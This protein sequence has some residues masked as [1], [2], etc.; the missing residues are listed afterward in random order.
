MVNMNYVIINSKFRTDNN[1]STSNFTYRLG[2]PIEVSD[3]AIKSVSIVNAEYNIKAGSNKLIVNNGIA[4]TTLTVPVGQYDI[5]ALLTVVKNYLDATYGGVNTLT[6]EPITNKVKFV[7]TT[8]LRYGTDPVTSPVGFILGFGDT[9]N[10]YYSPTGVSNIV[11]APYLPNLQGSNNFHIVSN[12]LAS[13]QGS[14]LKNNEKRSIILSVPVTEDFGNV[15]NYEVNEINLNK[16]HFA[17]PQN[18]QDIDIRIIDDD[19][20]VVNLNGTNVEI[21]L[22][23]VIASTLPYATE[24]DRM[25]YQ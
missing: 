20:Q 11:N 6:L 5:T 16:R 19:N 21:V 3:V 12:T 13:G 4:D 2:D 22:Q 25:G 8:A 15:I 7:T 23:V 10:A 24:G 9:P 14:L 18:I 17:R 1:D